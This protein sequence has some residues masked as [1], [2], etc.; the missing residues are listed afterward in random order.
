[1]QVRV[2]PAGSV[3]FIF[4]C[5]FL[6]STLVTVGFFRA[7]RMRENIRAEPR[8]ALSTFSYRA[9]GNIHAQTIACQSRTAI[10]KCYGVQQIQNAYSVTP[11]LAKGITGKGRSIIILDAY[12][13]PHLRHDVATFNKFFNLPTFPL[14][15]IAPNGSVTWKASNELQSSWSGEITLDVEWAHAIAPEASIVLVEAKTDDDKDLIHALDYAVN[16]NLGDVLSMSFGEGENCTKPD[17]MGLWHAAFEAAFKKNIT[18]LAASGDSGAAQQSCDGHSWKSVV[19]FP[20]S[21]VLVTGVGGTILNADVKTGHYTGEV[22]WEESAKQGATGGGFST[23]ISRPYYQSKAFIDS[24]MRG[25]PDVAYNASVIH[26]VVSIWSDGPKGLDA[27]YSTGGTSAGA[28]QWAAIIALVDQCSQR[29]AGLINPA[30]Y[31]IG[32]TPILYHSAFHDIVSGI[33]TITLTT[34]KKASK[35]YQGYQARTNWDP[36]TGLGSPIVSKL[37]PLLAILTIPT[38]DDLWGYKQS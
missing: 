34:T 31:Q 28:P 25:V 32:H 15:I 9:I 5:L 11:L 19:S 35:T 30:L 26:G 16:Q 7:Q 27:A 20:A 8:V 18:L 37:V 4:I 1:M 10:K 21:D 2:F 24:A 12:Q 17:S 29:R 13:A 3:K 23:Q 33:N 14:N 22:A 6:L 38:G 36:V